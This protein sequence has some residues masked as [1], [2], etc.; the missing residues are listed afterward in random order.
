MINI[1]RIKSMITTP[2]KEWEKIALEQT[3]FTSLITNYA[4]PLVLMGTIAFILSIGVIGI[5]G[6]R[7]FSLG[8]RF[9]LIHAL[10]CGLAMAGTA[11]SIDMLA[12]S[13][14]AEKNMMR[15]TQLAVYSFTPLLI[16]SAL[17]IIPT[18]DTIISTLVQL[19]GIYGLYIMY[20]GLDCMKLTPVDK[21]LPY[22]FASIVVTVGIYIISR[23]IIHNILKPTISD[24][25]SLYQQH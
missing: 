21:K 10:S 14:Q 16:L 5:D 12:S 7:S 6:Y 25:L 19:G 23:S 3:S 2:K 8:I 4:F 20:Q 13:F 17:Y 9:G 22:M 18:F 1:N 24:I 11:F 15:S